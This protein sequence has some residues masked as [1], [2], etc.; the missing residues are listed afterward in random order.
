MILPILITKHNAAALVITLPPPV[1]DTLAAPASS[2]P[3]I[4]SGIG[5]VSYY[6]KHTELGKR[7]K[8]LAF[9]AANP[10]VGRGCLQPRAALQ[11]RGTANK[12][13]F[14]RRQALALGIARRRQD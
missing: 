7:Y 4:V 14:R 5:L 13:E 12:P 8:P 9:V 10:R 6:E 2:P 11:N 3:D 1:T